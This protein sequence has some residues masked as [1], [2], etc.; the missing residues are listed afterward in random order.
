M[1][2][3][4]R[5]TG[6]TLNRRQMLRLSSA[7]GVGAVLPGQAVAQQRGPAAVAPAAPGICSTP[8]TAVATTKYGKV[9]GYV[10]D[11]VL[12]FK[13]VPYGAPT[14]GENRWL[15]AKPPAAWDG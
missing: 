14:G 9:R 3:S 5:R 4:P 8:R 11:G 2:D 10:D 12:T 1:S 6:S 13:G 15:P 7:V